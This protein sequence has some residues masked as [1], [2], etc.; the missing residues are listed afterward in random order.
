MGKDGGRL[1]ER[2]EA[3]GQGV[4]RL[5]R[6]HW[7]SLKV[8]VRVRSR[9]THP[10]LRT[11]PS[12]VEPDRAATPA[13]LSSP[14]SASLML[15]IDTVLNAVGFSGFGGGIPGLVLGLGGGGARLI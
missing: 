5:S 14:L 10:S 11:T 12:A 6:C 8:K 3:G 7:I 9:G 13:T 2:R 15:P 1:A 4:R